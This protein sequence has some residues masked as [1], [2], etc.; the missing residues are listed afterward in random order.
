MKAKRSR[1]PAP[2]LRCVCVKED[3]VL[4]ADLAKLLD[5]LND[6]RT[7]EQNGAEPKACAPRHC[8]DGKELT[9]PDF[10]VHEHD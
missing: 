8:P 5:R 2:T 6:L 1:V 4:A 7:R 9:H 3:L 10:V